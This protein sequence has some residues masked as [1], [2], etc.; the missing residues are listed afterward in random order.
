MDR[1]QMAAREAVPERMMRRSGAGTQP[2]RYWFDPA[3]PYVESR[4]ASDSAAACLP[5]THPNLSD[6]P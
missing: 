6:H 5:H 3:M 2:A 4:R 1:H